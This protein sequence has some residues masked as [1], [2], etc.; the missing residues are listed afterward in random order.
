MTFDP[1]V[2]FNILLPPII[3]H[4]GYSLKKVRWYGRWCHKLLSHRTD[5]SLRKSPQW[6]QWERLVFTE[7][8]WPPFQGKSRADV[9][10][11]PPLTPATRDV[12]ASDR[13]RPTDLFY[14]G[15]IPAA[16]AHISVINPSPASVSA[17]G[18]WW[19][20]L[21]MSIVESELLQRLDL[22]VME[23]ENVFKQL[24]IS[25][26]WSHREGTPPRFPITQWRMI[27]DERGETFWCRA[28]VQSIFWGS[29]LGSQWGGSALS[30]AGGVALDADGVGLQSRLTF[31]T[32]IN[33]KCQQIAATNDYFHCL[34]IC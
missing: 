15:G 6:P 13:C 16:A 14:L 33:S 12:A 4:A 19:F 28:P 21:R 31:D 26:I 10:L 27:S 3:F 1:E 8:K 17:D 24:V 25:D 18:R 11:F 30:A 29:G 22:E 2:F 34:L 23:S 20:F 9:F 5:G 7:H 32:V